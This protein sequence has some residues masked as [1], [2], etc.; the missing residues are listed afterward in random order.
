[1][2]FALALL[3]GGLSNLRDPGDEPYKF[4]AEAGLQY[5]VKGP[6]VGLYVLIGHR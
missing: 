1:V 5:P 4:S 6:A 3:P 2:A